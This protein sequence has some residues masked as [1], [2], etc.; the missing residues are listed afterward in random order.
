MLLLD[1]RLADEEKPRLAV[2]VG[3]ALRTDAPLFA[4]Q[5]LRKGSETAFR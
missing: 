3:K 2:M 5:R 1:G 4:G